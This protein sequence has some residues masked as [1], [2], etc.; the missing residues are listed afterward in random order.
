MVINIYGEE[1]KYSKNNKRD[2][3][4]IKIKKIEKSS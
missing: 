4:K 2:K 1:K 3:R